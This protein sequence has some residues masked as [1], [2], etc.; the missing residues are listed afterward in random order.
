MRTPSRT[1]HDAPALAAFYGTGRGKALA[2][3]ALTFIH[4]QWGASA[5]RSLHFLCF[6]FPAPGL[7]LFVRSARSFVLL[8]PSFVGAVPWRSDGLNQSAVVDAA[9][10]PV[11]EAS[12]DRALVFHTLEHL[13]DPVSFLE[14]LWRALAPG[15]RVIF[16]LPNAASPFSPRTFKTLLAEKG[17]LPVAQ[18][19]ALFGLGTRSD[20]PKAASV[21]RALNP[22]SGLF[23]AAFYLIE[24][25]KRQDNLVAAR[26]R[27]PKTIRARPIPS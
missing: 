17:F 2:D 10:L 16:L 13:D 22:K 27:A 26:E 14:E 23:G 7:K 20:G 9:R 12:F 1:A 8:T 18:G 24:A 11:R 5:P 3:D 19:G 6:G 21:L 15:G 25:E 4:G